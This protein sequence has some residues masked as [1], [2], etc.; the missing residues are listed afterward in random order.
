MTKY[1]GYDDPR[2]KQLEKRIKQYM[3]NNAEDYDN[4]TTLAEVSAD[5]YLVNDWLD[6]DTHPI[7]D[8]AYLIWTEIHDNKD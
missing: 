4:C 8:W 1:P 5:A 6:I 3:Y 2:I 7:W